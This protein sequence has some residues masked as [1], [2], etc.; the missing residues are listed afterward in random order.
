M[1]RTTED[2]A[3]IHAFVDG[4]FGSGHDDVTPKQFTHKMAEHM[5]DSTFAELVSVWKIKVNIKA[6][7]HCVSV[8]KSA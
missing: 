2:G 1:K 8:W 5:Q 7:R 6:P 3:A 4:T